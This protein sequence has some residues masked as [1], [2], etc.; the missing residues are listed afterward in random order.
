MEVA[1]WTNVDPEMSTTRTY[2]RFS[3]WIGAKP[4]RFGIVSRLYEDM[5]AAYLTESLRN[6]FYNDAK[7]SNKFQS[8]NSMYFEWEISTNNIKRIEF[9][10]VPTEDGAN[11]TEITMAF[12]EH[13]YEKFDIFRIDKT[14]QQCFVLARPVRKRDDYWEYQVRLIDNDYSEI[15]NFDGCQVGDT[16]MFISN[17]Q[18]ELHEEGFIKY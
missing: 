17:A 18:P 16:T 1:T 13:Y 2:E 10:A 15:L 4:E 6:I 7:S 9:A 5:T 3:K 8:I 11:G 14:G 12:K